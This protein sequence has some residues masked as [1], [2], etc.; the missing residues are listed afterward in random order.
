MQESK[1]T[2][3][4]RS[5]STARA[6]SARKYVFVR[7]DASCPRFICRIMNFAD[8]AFYE[9]HRLQ[10]SQVGTHG[11]HAPTP[12]GWGRG[13]ASPAR[14][15]SAKLLCEPSGAVSSLIRES[16][17]TQ[18]SGLRFRALLTEDGDGRVRLHGA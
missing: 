2:N 16:R 17:N 4:D 8:L 6:G 13:R 14:H 7:S 9:V 5:T 10:I 3:V 18:W 1:V 15:P 11:V 12:S